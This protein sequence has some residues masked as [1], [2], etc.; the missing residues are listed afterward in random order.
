MA[1]I[2]KEDHVTAKKYFIRVISIAAAHPVDGTWKDVQAILDEAGLGSLGAPSRDPRFG[3][4]AE[5]VRSLRTTVNVVVFVVALQ[6]LVTMLAL[7][8]WRYGQ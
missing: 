8:A 5:E 1:E 3:P 4:L 6:A 7:L 2:I